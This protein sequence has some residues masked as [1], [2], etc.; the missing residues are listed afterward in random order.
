MWTNRPISRAA[1]RLMSDR[2]AIVPCSGLE[3]SAYLD[4]LRR[5][6]THI[7]AYMP[8]EILDLDTVA[9][10][11][12]FLVSLA[13]AWDHGDALCLVAL[14]RD[15]SAF[16]AQIY[17]Q[18]IDRAAG[19]VEIGYF[20]DVGHQGQGY[21][22]EAVRRVSRF[23]FD[24]AGVHKICLICDAGNDASIRVAERAGFALEGVLRQHALNK[25]GTRPDR[26]FYARLRSDG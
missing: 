4:V 24:E 13:S 1:L 3:P 12:Q 2:M 5:N 7:D 6:R 26:C 17:V 8:D 10:V 23:L 15:R 22:A 11:Q 25:D 9:D 16:L 20:T 21:A 19:I 18:P 14:E